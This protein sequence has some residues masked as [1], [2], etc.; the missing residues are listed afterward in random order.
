MP[1]ITI[2]DIPQALF[3]R[4]IAFALE[5]NISVEVQVK[6]MLHTTLYEKARLLEIKK[7]PTYNQ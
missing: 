3:D 7:K 5:N 2:N 6:N 1:D 4:L